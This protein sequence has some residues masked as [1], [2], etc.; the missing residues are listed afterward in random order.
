[1][2]GTGTERDGTVDFVPGRFEDEVLLVDGVWK[3]KQKTIYIDAFWIAKRNGC[4]IACDVTAQW[5]LLVIDTLGKTLYL[6]RIYEV[7]Q[8]R[9]F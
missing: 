1:M 2:N 3:S 5:E 7:P 8:D 4:C 6:E 9:V